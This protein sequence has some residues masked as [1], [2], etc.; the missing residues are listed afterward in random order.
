MQKTEC[1]KNPYFTALSSYSL[2][3]GRTWG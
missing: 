2:R 1:A 3:L